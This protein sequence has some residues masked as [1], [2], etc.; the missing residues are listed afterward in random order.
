MAASPLSEQDLKI[1]EI[2]SRFW[3]LRGSKEQYILDHL[4]LRSVEYYYRLSKL[5]E[6]EAAEAHSPVLVHRLRRRRDQMIVKKRRAGA[7]LEGES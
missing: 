5:I 3:K 2:E 1:L 4:G 6:T 7:D